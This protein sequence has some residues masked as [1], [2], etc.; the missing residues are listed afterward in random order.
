[1]PRANDRIGPYQLI[2]K[3]GKGAFGE[4]WL[5]S[6]WVESFI[7]AQPPNEIVVAQITGVEVVAALARRVH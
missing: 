5:G 1:M 2:S 4:V 6:T 3:L 7:D